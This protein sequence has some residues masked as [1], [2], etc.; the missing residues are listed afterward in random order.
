MSTAAVRAESS[1]ARPSTVEIFTARAEARALLWQAGEFDL[2]HAVDELQAAAER[3]GLVEQLGQDGVQQIMAKAFTV[4]REHLPTSIVPDELVEAEPAERGPVAVS[5]LMAA[6]HLVCEGHAE[7]FRRWLGEHS[8]QERMAI[9]K[10]LEAKR[11]RFRQT[12]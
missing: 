7:R 1:A 11:C 6:E 5:T 12:K 8:A 4:V 2:H 9:H 10:H 3:D